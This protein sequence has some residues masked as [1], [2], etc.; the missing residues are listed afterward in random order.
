MVGDAE[1]PIVRAIL[2]FQTSWGI[3]DDGGAGQRLSSERNR[4]R[5]AGPDAA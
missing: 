5:N 2:S 4:R 3:P 1:A